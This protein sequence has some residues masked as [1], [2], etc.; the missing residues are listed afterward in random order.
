[1]CP[2]DEMKQRNN[3]GEV[4][5]FEKVDRK[6]VNVTDASLAVKRAVKVSRVA[7]VAIEVQND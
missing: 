5:Y 3:V 4:N 6:G 7:L 2:A 1:M